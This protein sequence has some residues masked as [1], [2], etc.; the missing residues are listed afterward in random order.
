M[1]IE[2]FNNTAAGALAGPII[3]VPLLPIQANINPASKDKLSIGR[4]WINKATDSA[5][6]LTSI[7]NN[8]AHWENITGGAGVFTSVTSATFVNAGTTMDAVGNI[9][10][11]TGNISATLGNVSAGGTV[12]AGTSISATTSITAGTTIGAGSG[13]TSTT[14]NIVAS[15]GQVNAATTMTAGTGITAT[16]GN[17]VATAGAVNAGTTMTAGTGIIATTG[18]ISADTGDFIAVT[19]HKG[20]LL[21]DL[22]RVMSHST[23]PNG[24]VTGLKGSLCLVPSGSGVNDRIF[25]NTDNAMAWTAIVT[26]A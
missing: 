6:I 9:T 3:N 24:A 23:N 26:V 2:A 18:D 4:I 8:A 19:Q 22:V 16:T 13:I 7:V 20:L 25:I 10:S 12:S 14:G 11:D 17:I 15:A 5:F 21:T 1:A